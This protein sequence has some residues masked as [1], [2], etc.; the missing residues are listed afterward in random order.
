MGR[1]A[2]LVLGV[3]V[4]AAGFVAGTALRSRL[5]APTEPLPA[6]APVPAVPPAV[7]P[8]PEIPAGPE[9]VTIDQTGLD[10]AVTRALAGL[11][12]VRWLSVERLSERQGD[13]EFRWVRRRVEATV[14]VAQPDAVEAI[15]KEVESAGGKVLSRSADLVRVGVSQAGLTLVT[16]EI[17][18]LASAIQGPR[19]AIIF[20]DAGGSLSDL[21]IIIALGR[22]VTI[23]VLPGL[24]FSREVAERARA[25]GLDVLLHLPMEAEDASKALGPGGISG[26]MSDEEI[27][28]VVREGLDGVPGAIGVNN[29]MG[30]K[31]TA[32]ERIMRAVLGVV[33][34]RRLMFVDSYTSPKSRAAQ[35]A[36]EMGIPAGVRAVFLDNEDDPDAIRTQITRLLALAVQ[37]GQVI[38][39]GHAQRQTAKV[40]QEMLAEFDRQG[41][42]LV[43]ISVLVR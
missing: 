2:W 1:T 4:L 39:I 27:A 7:E 10:G 9:V 38:A 12:S 35:L 30:S 3:V 41:I 40:L 22:P 34:E 43:P 23:A 19:V 36:A 21:D 15:R 32:D 11:G 20:D 5:S 13:R 31:G 16:H 42:R 26:E 8:G 14:R 24:R 33:R 6:L 37:R 18:L 29:H 25:A 17:R 28:T